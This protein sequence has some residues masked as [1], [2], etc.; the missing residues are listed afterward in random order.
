MRT[1]HAN[2]ATYTYPDKHFC[3]AMPKSVDDDFEGFEWIPLKKT[4]YDSKVFPYC[5][6]CKTKYVPIDG[7]CFKCKFKENGKA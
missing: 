1:I 6:R 3:I 2:G 7:V 4:C 5:Q